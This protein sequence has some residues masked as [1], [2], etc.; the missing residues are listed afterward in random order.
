MDRA[1]LIELAQSTLEDARAAMRLH[2]KAIE[3]LGVIIGQLQSLEEPEEE[4]PPPAH[5][6]P[7]AEPPRLS[8]IGPAAAPAHS[9]PPPLPMSFGDPGSYEIDERLNE[10]IL[11][12]NDGMP[13]PEDPQPA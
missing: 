2:L 1:D 13:D 7:A 10:R 6:R 12:F 11:A 9:G 4:L 8:T 3:Q 5:L